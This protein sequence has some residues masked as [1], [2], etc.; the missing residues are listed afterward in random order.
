MIGIRSGY[1]TSPNIALVKYWG[2]LNEEYIIPLNNSI[3]LTF[4]VEDL[5]TVTKMKFSEK[6]KEDILMINGVAEK[7]SLRLAKLL[8]WVRTTYAGSL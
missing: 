7:I 6:Y 1:I 5:K 8:N 4:D 2:K 3:G